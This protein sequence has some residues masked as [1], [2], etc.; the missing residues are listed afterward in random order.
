MAGEDAPRNLQLMGK[1]RQTPMFSQI[2][3]LGIPI[4][5]CLSRK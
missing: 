4:A 3:V 1:T 2:N 5:L